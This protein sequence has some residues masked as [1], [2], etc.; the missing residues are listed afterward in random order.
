[1]VVSRPQFIAGCCLETS[2]SCCVS[3]SIQLLITWQ[4]VSPRER[5]RTMS[6]YTYNVILEVAYHFCC[7]LW[8]T[9][10]DL[11]ENGRELHTGVNTRKQKSVG[12]IS[13]ADYYR[14]CLRNI[15]ILQFIQLFLFV[16]VETMS[17][18]LSNFLQPWHKQKS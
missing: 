7:T 13:E 11:V 15:M 16:S 6:F 3:L 18:A 12:A 5:E 4:V 8:L 10:T 2:I 17:N 9:L 1:M 14:M